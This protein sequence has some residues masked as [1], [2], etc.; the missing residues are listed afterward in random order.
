MRRIARVLAAG[1]GVDV[2]RDGVGKGDVVCWVGW[3]R[4]A[5]WVLLEQGKDYTL[6]IEQGLLKAVGRLSV[7]VDRFCC[8]CSPARIAGS[9]KHGRKKIC[10]HS[11]E[12]S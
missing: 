4:E 6:A 3:K 9:E 1:K 5:R 12:P 7:F 8:S 11:K 10:G 2:G